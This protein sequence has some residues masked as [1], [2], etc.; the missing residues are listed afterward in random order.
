MTSIKTGIYEQ[1]AIKYSIEIIIDK[2]SLVDKIKKLE[3]TV[4]E[5]EKN[6][7]NGRGYRFNMERLL[8][9]KQTGNMLLEGLSKG[10]IAKSL[11]LK[12]STIKNYILYFK[13]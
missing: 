2:E 3:E 6:N 12:D 11:E 10:K 4:L 13:D 9:I 7:Y 8:R 1:Q 5:R